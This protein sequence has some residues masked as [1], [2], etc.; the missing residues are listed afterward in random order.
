MY[1]FNQVHDELITNGKTIILE[2]NL[3][4]MRVIQSTSFIY[5]TFGVNSMKVIHIYFYSSI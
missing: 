5:M 1:S 4:V 3:Y 2:F